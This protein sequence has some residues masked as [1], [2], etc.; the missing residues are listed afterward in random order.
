MLIKVYGGTK[1]SGSSLCDSCHHGTVAEGFDSK[2]VIYCTFMSKNVDFRVAT[3]TDY[4][5]RATPGIDEMK[6]IAWVVESRT[7]GKWGFTGPE[8]QREI[9]VRPPGE[10][11]NESPTES[12][13]VAHGHKVRSN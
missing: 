7:R 5:S 12:R 10:D 9:V 3:C 13:G 2:K 8:Q 4:H 6:R 11:P 1:Q